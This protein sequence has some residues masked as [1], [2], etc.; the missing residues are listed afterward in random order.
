MLS[1]MSNRILRL[2]A[3]RVQWRAVEG[4]VVAVDLESS[5]Y[6]AVNPTAALIWPELERGAT[7]D[8]LA[9]RL[10]RECGIDRAQ[11]AG[12]VGEF[13]AAL[14]ALELLER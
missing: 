9:D 6:Y 3:D 4:E 13:V 2:R 10:V 1:A 11:A 7:F 12:E 8:G 5:V 14:D